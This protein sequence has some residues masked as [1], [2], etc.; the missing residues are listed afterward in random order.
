MWVIC[1]SFSSLFVEIYRNL[2]KWNKMEQDW[3][4]DMNWWSV[5]SIR[6]PTWATSAWRVGRVFWWTKRAAA[7]QDAVAPLAA[8]GR[9]TPWVLWVSW[10]QKI[11]KYYKTII[12]YLFI[13]YQL[14]GVELRAQ[15]WWPLHSHDIH[16]I[17]KTSSCCFVHL[18]V[19]K[20]KTHPS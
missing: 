20:V 13:S 7:F 18:L 14:Y 5:S 19:C 12:S 9:A 17:G 16:D 8:R 15:V 6:G 4:I 10:L 1:E 11:G 3:W 2:E